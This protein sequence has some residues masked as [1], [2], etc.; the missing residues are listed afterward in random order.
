MG[1]FDSLKKAF[2]KPYQT[3]SV[4]QAEELLGSGATLIDVRS[5]QEWRTG[6]APQAKHVPL[7][8]LQTSTTGINRN[9]PV[10]AV[11]ASG[12]RSASAARLLAAQG[13]QA[14]SVRGGM[15]AWRQAGEP[16]R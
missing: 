9:K 4:A 11:C 8:R 14:Y 6:R 5:A 2:S 12:V 15:A 3:I 10:I 1:L 7:D 16:V 13:Y